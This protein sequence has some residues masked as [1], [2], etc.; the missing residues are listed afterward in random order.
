[1]SKVEVVKW[2]S[3]MLSRF[4]FTAVM[5]AVYSAEMLNSVV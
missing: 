5:V 4:A 3:K 1:M 2:Y